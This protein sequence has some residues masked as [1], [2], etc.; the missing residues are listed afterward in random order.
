MMSR[1]LPLLLLFVT[2]LFI[3]AEVWQVTS[4]QDG[5]ELWLAVLLFSVL[6]VA[7]LLVRLPEEVDR[8]DDHVDDAFLLDACR[9]TPL[10]Q[11]SPRARR[12]P[13]LRPGLLRRGDR[14]TSS[15]TW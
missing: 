5:G 8:T 14:A 9:G 1:A 6:A 13:R 4:R 7:F 10:E 2:F 12:R 15:A 11:V 3:N